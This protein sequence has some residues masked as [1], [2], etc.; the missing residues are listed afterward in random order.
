[1][2]GEKFDCGTDWFFTEC[3]FDFLFGGFDLGQS[4]EKLL[5]E[6]IEAI[7]QWFRK[8][9]VFKMFDGV[10]GPVRQT[11]GLVDSMLK[12]KTLNLEFDTGLFCDKLLAQASELTAVMCLRSPF[13]AYS[14]SL[15]ASRESVFESGAACRGV[16]EGATTLTGRSASFNALASE[17]PV[18]PAS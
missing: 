12:K 14:A 9:N 7:S 16:F 4:E 10:A 15:R 2:S 5:D 17:Y 6:G 3:L 13:A 11:C 18:G 1:M 8:T